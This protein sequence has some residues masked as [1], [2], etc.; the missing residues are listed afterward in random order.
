M[1]YTA[2]IL[3]P[4][5][6]TLASCGGGASSDAKPEPLNTA[7]AAVPAP[8]I[9]SDEVVISKLYDPDYSVPDGFFVDERA[10]LSQSYTVYHVMDDSVSYELCTDD[11]ATAEAWEDADNASRSVNG[12]FVGAYENDRYFEFIR[13]LSYTD[14]V[15]NVADLTS[16]GF[17]RVF[18]CS[19]TVRDGVDRSVL[20]GYAGKLNARPLNP[21]AIRNFAEYFW[22]FTFF[23]QRYRKVL[24]SNGVAGGPN[25]DHAL[26]LAFAT[27]QGTGQCDLVEVVSWNFSTNAETGEISSSFDTI[28]SFEAEL[29]SG[30]PRLCL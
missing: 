15:G 7:T 12:Y 29:V 8:Q 10:G 30:T 24:D 19:N 13:E 18:K 28:K 5:L 22:Q 4:M 14:D 6:A 2:V 27:S 20:S 11:F 17:A 16:P 1:K 25:L 26:L 9:P 23:P 3:L 21:D